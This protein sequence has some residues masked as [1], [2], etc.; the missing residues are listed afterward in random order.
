MADQRRTG[1][2]AFL[3][4]LA[5]ALVLALAAAALAPDRAPAFALYWNPIYRAEI[6]LVVLAIAYLLGIAGWMAWHGLAF[7]RIELPGGAALERDTAELDAAAVDLDGYLDST[8]VRLDA[9]EATLDDVIDRIEL[10]RRGT[11]PGR[12][13]VP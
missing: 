13:G 1:P 9:V 7:Q 6:A 10:I 11:D 3:W 8:S 4:V 2:H 12:P 5:G